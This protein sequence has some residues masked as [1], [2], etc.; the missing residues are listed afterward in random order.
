[1]T[2]AWQEDVR[3]IMNAEMAGGGG[4][5]PKLPG[6]RT[7]RDCAPLTGFMSQFMLWKRTIEFTNAMIMRAP[8]D[9]IQTI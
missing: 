1:M 9:R 3:D 8:M 5:K 4:G 6:R 7:C 2:A